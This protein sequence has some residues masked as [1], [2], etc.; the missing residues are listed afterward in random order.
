M[1]KKEK[2]GKKE[3][4]LN[5]EKSSKKE[6]TKDEKF[7]ELHRLMMNQVYDGSIESKK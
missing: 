4:K 3:M 2:N 5:N 1:K 6:M 7:D